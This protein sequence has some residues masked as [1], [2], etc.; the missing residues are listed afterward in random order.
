MHVPERS[1]HEEASKYLGVKEPQGPK[2]YDNLRESDIQFWEREYGYR[3][4]EPIE[5]LNKKIR[6]KINR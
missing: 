4:G 2:V 1:H 3:R 6:D 5:I